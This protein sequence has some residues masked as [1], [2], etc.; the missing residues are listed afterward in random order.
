MCGIFYGNRRKCAQVLT[1][2]QD[3]GLDGVGLYFPRTG[4][5]QRFLST[6]D[7]LHKL[8][9]YTAFLNR[10][11]NS[12][13]AVLMHHRKA[14]IGAISAENVHPFVGNR[15]SLMQNGTNKFIAEVGDV[16][17]FDTDNDTQIL[18]QIIEEKCDNLLKAAEFLTFLS[19][20]GSYKDSI[21]AIFL[22]DNA[23]KECLF[24]SDATRNTHITTSD[25]GNKIEEIRSIG[26]G[27]E[28]TTN[29]GYF[30]FNISTGEVLKAKIKDEDFNK[31]SY[32]AYNTAINLPSKQDNFAHTGYKKCNLCATLVKGGYYRN[33]EGFVCWTC[34]YKIDRAQEAESSDTPEQDD[35]CNLCFSDVDV[36]V[37]PY[38]RKGA[39]GE[40]MHKYKKLCSNCVQEY[41]Q[42]LLEESGFRLGKKK[43][44][45]KGERKALRRRKAERYRLGL[46][47]RRR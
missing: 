2:Q 34:S 9:S 38:Y 14:S 43:A 32:S 23:T 6:V 35:Y 1:A 47:Q 24:F 19:P 44:L 18:L 22:V 17:G 30:I 10:F 16:F 31:K 4:T 8:P 33:E 26:E 36:T 37:N 27:G 40:V 11:A 13:N 39:T 41:S 46:E 29:K 12:D 15:F 20:K 21:G 25:G 42:Q 45:S 3:R 28:K 7:S 5:V